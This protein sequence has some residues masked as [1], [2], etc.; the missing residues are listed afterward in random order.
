M[1]SRFLP[2]DWK[3]T[4]LLRPLLPLATVAFGGCALGFWL[5][6][7]WRDAV[8]FSFSSWS[9]ALI[10][11][12]LHLAALWASRFRPRVL[13]VLW[14]ALFA[15]W[16]LH[17]A[18]R[19]TPPQNDVSQIVRRAP[20]NLQPQRKLEVQ[21]R[22]TI[23][24][25]PKTGSFGVEFPLKIERVALQNTSHR[26]LDVAFKPTGNV[27]IRLP[28][29]G[30]NL[31]DG[32]TISL[33]GK[34]ADLSRAGNP[35]E[36]ESR[37]RFMN[38]R[39][40]SALQVR[41]NSDWK[42]LKRSRGSLTQL[43]NNAQRAIAQ[44]TDAAF[45]QNQKPFPRASSQLLVAMV[46][47]VGGLQEPLP[48]ATNDRFRAA[49]MSHLLVAS[50]TQVAF[51]ALVLLGGAKIVGLRRAGLLLLVLPILL[52]YALLTGGASSIWRAT[53]AG[54]CVAWALLLGR[55]VDGLS[56]WSLAV[57]LLLGL[58][59]MQAQD[60]GFQL[61]FGATWGLLVLAPPLRKLLKSAWG[62][63]QTEHRVL[64]AAALTLSAQIAT[65]PLLLYHFGRVSFVALG[66]NFLAIPLAGILVATGIIG[67]VLP[68][69]ALNYALIRGVDGLA[70]FAVNAPGAQSDAPPLRLAWTIFAY[71]LLLGALFMTRFPTPTNALAFFE[72][73]PQILWKKC[74]AHFP[75]LRPQSVVAVIALFLSVFVVWRTFSLQKKPLRVTL[76]DVGQGESIVIQA[77]N[78]RTILIDGGTSNDENR[79]EVGRAIIVPFLQARNISRLDAMILTHADADHCNALSRVVQEIPVGFALDGAAFLAASSTRSAN[80]NAPLVPEYEAVK[81]AWRE[82]RVPVRAAIEG[83]KIHLGDGAILTVLAPASPVLNGKSGDNNNSAVLRLDYGKTSFLFTADIE[84]EAEERLLRRGANLKCTVL[85]VAHHGSKTS[86]TP[87]FLQS[88]NP[89]LAIVSCGRYNQ[90][91][92]PAPQTMQA[93]AAQKTPTLRTDISGAIEV[94]CDGQTCDAQTFR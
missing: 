35:A 12:L 28:L 25:T 24:D 43:V 49:G 19:A 22:G 1:L 81:S 2:D 8:L 56:L 62:N 14:L 16:S 80:Q 63:G 55:D 38:A 20:D 69:G 37:A 4:L 83:Q 67:L 94:S 17:A 34:L 52:I 82:A 40:W 3:R 77:P 61:T 86:S 18:Q 31:L 88:A 53:L 23:A 45:I 21:L 42:L 57:L 60:L 65:T 47:G 90:F 26:V 75:L 93:L 36:R 64:D 58:N 50:G 44:R 11:L 13:P 68:L 48:T 74:R 51:L 87:R 10:L 84:R 66:A 71:A 91:G 89:S 29:N 72:T 32:D 15:L 33:T 70:T 27:W 54:M 39:C 78:G 79:G 9:V 92:H 46:F 76:L 6:Q 73:M 59:A 85:K 30:E 5:A 7:S 41:K